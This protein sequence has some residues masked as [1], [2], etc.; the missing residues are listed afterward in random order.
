MAHVSSSHTYSFSI[1]G[2]PEIEQ[3]ENEL[4]K[5]KAAVGSKAKVRIKSFEDQRDGYSMNVVVT[6]A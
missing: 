6:S 5:A 2:V 3:V 4:A 1:N